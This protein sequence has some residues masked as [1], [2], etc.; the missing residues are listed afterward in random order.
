MFRHT[1]CCDM[2]EHWEKMQMLLY[3]ELC[4]HGPHGNSAA[5]CCAV[6]WAVCVTSEAIMV[7]H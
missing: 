6:V 2:V 7:Q 3:L 5:L 4:G 1:C